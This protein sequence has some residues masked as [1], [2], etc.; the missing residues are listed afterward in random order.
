MENRKLTSESVTEGHPDKICDIISDSV[1]DFCLKY[2]PYSRVAC[3]CA[4]KNKTL[5]IFGEI[6]TKAPIMEEVQSIA[7]NTLDEIGYDGLSFKVVTEISIQSPDIAMGVDVGGAG[8]QGIMFGYACNETPELMPLSIS[9]AHKL[10]KQLT[11]IRKNLPVGRYLKPDGKAQVTVEYDEMGRPFRIDTILIST[12]H[13]E[14]IDQEGIRKIVETH[15]IN[16]VVPQELMDE[17]TKI[18]VNPT[19]RFVICGPEGDS[20]LTG[21]KI[22]V[23]NYGCHSKVGG[24]AY[25]VDGDTEYLSPEGFKKI[26]EYKGEKVGQWEDGVLTFVQPYAYIETPATK[27]YHIYN[28]KN[29]DMV[30]SENHDIIMYTSK[31]NL[32]KKRAKDIIENENIKSGNHGF[33]PISFIYKN[34]EKGINMSDDEIRLQVAFCADGTILKNKKGRVRVKKA[35]KRERM[36]F[37]L[38]AT[39]TQFEEKTYPCDNYEY[40]YFIFTPPIINKSLYE[41][42]NSCNLEQF[43]IIAEECQKWDGKKGV[44]R[45]TIKQE[46]DFIQFIFLS[47]YG[48]N[49]SITVNDRIGENYHETY[50][51]KSK[52]YEVYIKQTKTTNLKRCTSGKTKIYCETFTPKN[53]TMYCFSVPSGALVLR[54]NDKV[55]I[56]G[57][58]GKDVTKVDRSAA[59]MARHIAKSIVGSGLAPKC[60]VQLAYAIGVAEPVSIYVDTFGHGEITEQFIR[61]NFDLT[62]EGII[63]TFDLRRPIYKQTAKNGHF[64]HGAFPW[65]NVQ[66]L[67]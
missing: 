18:L 53:Q 26:S 14:N 1:L 36:R 39:K 61:D 30:V 22:V 43:K 29:L 45:T 10:T 50:K 49:V 55:F 38:Q 12:S 63:K 11:F 6:T 27:M 24:G 56:T 57:N 52:L 23:D 31:G 65:E 48:T 17:N 59:Y 3:E 54:R 25:C 64:G 42:F 8:D 46:A 13:T 66:I 21:R 4:I 35:E 67:L 40:S 28:K 51:R 44:F 58:S 2:D 16:E 7:K 20:G 15:V 34:E 62:P 37:L 9:L 41:C 32:I 5:F 60:E 47:V 19:G 33:I